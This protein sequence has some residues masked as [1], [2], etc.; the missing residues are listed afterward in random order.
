MKT[1][2]WLI[3]LIFTGA[4]KDKYNAPVHI[5]SSGYLVVEGFINVGGG[6]TVFKLTR[7]TGLDSPKVLSEPGAQVNVESENGQT[8]PLTEQGNGQYSIP[9]LG[10]DF[11][12]RYRVRI[13]TTDGNEYVSDFSSPKVTPPIDSIS[14]KPANGGIWIYTTTHDP[15]NNS[16]YYQW[17]YEET[18]EYASR[19]I[20]TQMY[21]GNGKFA[22]RPD[23]LYMHVCYIGDISTAISIG[24]TAKLTNDLMYEY[25]LTF[26]PYSTTNKLSRRYTI[27]VK[28]YVLTKEWYEWKEKVK[29]NT[30]QLGSIFDA[31]P[32]DI[33]GNI[34][35]VSNPYLPVIGYVGCSS[36]T[37]KRIF[38]SRSELPQTPVY[39]GYED[40]LADTVAN[41]EPD[42]MIYFDGGTTIPISPIFS[43]SGP[44]VP[45]AYTGSSSFCVDC[46]FFGGVLEKPAF[47]Q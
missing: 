41:V 8:Y 5:P 44:P 9:Q 4:C 32:S 43:T 11:S 36:E 10:V 24:S 22:Y 3:L 35:C 37:E 26:I 27:L 29:K 12:Q 45:I 40:C 1:I 13:R 25:P 21:L 47:W 39:T 2:R 46:R 7:A 6:S 15:T 23:S 31:Q 17:D 33:S 42:I 14:W 30:E 38:I 16:R 19:F 20:S 28:Q 18:W 34:H